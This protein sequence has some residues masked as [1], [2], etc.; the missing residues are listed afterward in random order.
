MA[1]S[2]S[3]SSSDTDDSG[4]ERTRGISESSEVTHRTTTINATR[5][6]I[7]E[8]A[9]I[10]SESPAASFSSVLATGTPYDTASLATSRNTGFSTAGASQSSFATGPPMV[11]PPYMPQQRLQVNVQLGQHQAA[12]SQISPSSKHTRSSLSATSFLLY[13]LHSWLDHQHE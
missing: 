10:R 11:Q 12:H 5:T 9:T 2:S 4:S 1:S 13:S 3:F 8:S 7:A 6:S